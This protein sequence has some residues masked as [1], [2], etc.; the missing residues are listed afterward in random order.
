MRTVP[1]GN[2]ERRCR[3]QICP[4]LN[5]LFG[6]NLWYLWNFSL[7]KNV[8]R[9]KVDL[10]VFPG[11]RFSPE[12]NRIWNLTSDTLN[13]KVTTEKWK[14]AADF[15]CYRVDEY[16]VDISS[17]LSISEGIIF[18]AMQWTILLKQ[19]AKIQ[20]IFEGV[21]PPNCRT[22]GSFISIKQKNNFRTRPSFVR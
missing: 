21:S 4:S 20:R 10:W 6:L 17:F 12:R 5:D 9:I 15:L 18:C 8:S 1:I 11:S 7:L 16:V 3:C 14:A 22:E 19:F 13:F 2:Q